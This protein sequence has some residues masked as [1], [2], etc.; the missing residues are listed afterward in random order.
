[1]GKLLDAF[2]AYLSETSPEEQEK[3]WDRIK[4]WNDFGP[5]V[6][7]YF[8]LVLGMFPNGGVVSRQQ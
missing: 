7:E 8:S 4:K 6:M 2:K 1:M 5:D 3:D